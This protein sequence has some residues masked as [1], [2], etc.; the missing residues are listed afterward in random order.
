MP[1]LTGDRTFRRSL[2]NTAV[3]TVIVAPVSIVLALAIAMLI[4]AE[5]RGRAFFRTVYFLPVASLAR[6]HGHR[7]AVSCS[8]RRSAR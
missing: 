8:I 4:E 6:R 2:W 1:S 3:Y 7:L 5:T